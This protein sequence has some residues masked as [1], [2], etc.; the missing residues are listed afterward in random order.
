MISLI[1][2]HRIARIRFMR[3]YKSTEKS[4]HFTHG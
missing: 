1:L 2:L 4:T 3:P